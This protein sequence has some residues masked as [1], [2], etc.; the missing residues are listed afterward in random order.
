LYIKEKRLL[1]LKGWLGASEIDTSKPL[2]MT[3][4][5]LWEILKQIDKEV[6][7]PASKDTIKSFFQFQ[8]V[9][10]FKLGRPAGK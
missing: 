3:T 9:C 8:N 4:G 2:V 7:P 1:I 6:F 5:E 10:H